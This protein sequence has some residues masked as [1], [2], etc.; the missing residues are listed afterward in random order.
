MNRCIT[1]HTQFVS[2]ALLA[3][4][5]CASYAEPEDL[6]FDNQ[7]VPIV[8]SAS[9]LPQLQTEAPASITVIDRALI[10]ASGATQI[11][12]LF[13]LVP[14]MQ[15]GNARG[16]FPVV[17][18]QGLTS[19]F[20]QGVQVVIDGSSVYSPIF[21]GVVWSTLPLALEDIERIEVVRGPNNASFGANAFQGVINITTTHA[22]QAPRLT[23]SFRTN[24]NQSERA[25]FRFADTQA[26]K[27]LNYRISLSSEKKEGYEQFSDDS[28]KDALS[29]RV[30]FR[31]DTKN[32]LQLNFAAL[33]SKRQT[34]S[35]IPL[36]LLFDPKRNRNEST[37]LAQI[38]WEQQINDGEQVSTR[39]SYHHFDGKDKYNVPPFG[40]LDVGSE[41]T[42]WDFN[43]EHIVKFKSAQRLIW[44][45]GATHESVYAPFRMN[46]SKTRTNTRVRLFGNLESRLTNQLIFNTGAL[47]EHEQI[48]G[49]NVSPR[50]TL[51]YLSS[52]N[53][54]YRITATK[55]FRTP[56]IPEEERDTVLF[57][58]PLQVSAE[59]IEPE[60]VTSFEAGYHG[61]Y[62]LNTLNT[63]VKLF[64]NDY[65]QLINNDLSNTLPVLDNIDQAKTYGAE[66][67]L[68]YRPNRRNI[69]HAGYAY[70]QVKHAT[71]ER[72]NSSIPKHNFN[73]LFS[74]QYDNGFRNGIEYYY[75]SDMQYLGGQNDPQGIFQR[76]DLSAGK[77]IKL[78]NNKSI[79][80]NLNLQ[81]A[82]NKNT[83][84]HEPTTA[85]NL[86]YLEMKYL[87][88]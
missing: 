63:D 16:N 73:V 26:N 27:R 12:E 55:A 17:A 35:P 5:S 43:A 33:D 68:N 6:F 53:H 34:Q 52:P 21:G 36:L 54:A 38:T 72:L 4:L 84:F 49:L 60:T 1:F 76:L 50:I 70:T 13:R 75:T 10:K 11:P 3:S 61:I 65:K 22:S 41:S 8:L 66:I 48:T 80:I 56:V 2:L 58:A 32:T 39:L 7:I 28:S 71:D 82:L 18:Y 81:L 14:G 30:D 83:D 47:V 51:N 45:I 78:G 19:E 24:N 29:A 74:H 9:K 42:T 44:G 25:F 64:H 31:L 57:G 37:Q 67:E 88:H 69:L 85:D 77:L 40:T 79:D 62:W 20:P 15:V 86:I 59:N 23:T 87:A 46:S